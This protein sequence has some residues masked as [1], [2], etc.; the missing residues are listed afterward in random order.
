MTWLLGILVGLM[1]AAN[2]YFIFKP[3]KYDGQLLINTDEDGMKTFLLEITTAPENMEE[4]HDITL[5]VVSF[6]EDPDAG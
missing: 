2:L 5:K 6:E 4:S 3:V 1:L